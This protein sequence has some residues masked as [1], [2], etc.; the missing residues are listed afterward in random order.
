MR[1]PRGVRGWVGA[2]PKHIYKKRKRLSMTTNLRLLRLCIHRL[3]FEFKEVKVGAG[4]AEV[5]P[6]EEEDAVVEDIPND[7]VMRPPSVVRGLRRRRGRGQAEAQLHDN[8]P[9]DVGG[10]KD[11]SLLKSFR[12]HVAKAILEGEERSTLRLHQ[13]SGLL[14]S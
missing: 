12:K 4:T 2:S 10:P 9:L 6:H 3:E 1:P 7:E 11:L 5:H 13:H 14:G 8:A